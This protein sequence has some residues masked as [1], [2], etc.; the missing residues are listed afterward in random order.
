MGESGKQF[1]TAAEDIR[2]YAGQYDKSVQELKLQLVQANERT[3]E[4][5]EQ[6]R[7]LVGLLKDNNMATAKLMKHCNEV[8]RFAEQSQPEAFSQ[9][10][11][12]LK[13]Q[14]TI[15]KNADEEIIKS[16]ERNR[17]QMEDLVAEFEAQQENQKE[18]FGWMDPVF[19]H[20]VERKAG[21]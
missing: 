17:M 10:I 14:V 13:S 20:V 9:E 19:R 6:I 11:A 3:A 2:S 12:D 4:L 8:L 7:H 5:E 1:V 21:E 16:E 15:L 18:L